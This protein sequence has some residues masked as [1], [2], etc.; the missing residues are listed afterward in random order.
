MRNSVFGEE[1]N[2]VSGPVV[3]TPY[4]DIRLFEIDRGSI[5][6]TRCTSMY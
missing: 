2:V 4:R 1:A 5:G 6:L 3:D